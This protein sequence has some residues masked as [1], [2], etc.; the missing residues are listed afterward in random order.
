[1]ERT[2]EIDGEL[3]AVAAYLASR[4]EMLMQAWTT[5][6]AADAELTTASALPRTQFHDHIPDMLDAFEGRLRAWPGPDSG[7]ARAARKEDAGAHGLQR[8][9]QGYRLREV[10]REWGL[11]HLCL[12]DELDRY[13]GEGQVKD[14]ATMAIARR[15][16][17]QLINE[18]VGE[19]TAQYFRLR[20]IEAAGYVRDVEQALEQL[21]ELERRRAELWRQAA[22]D[23]RGNLG[24]LVNATTGLTHEGMPVEMREQFLR[25]LQRSVSSLHSMLDDVISL[26]RLQAGHESRDVKP[27]DVA[28]MLT[29]LCDT[30]RPVAGERG[31]Y[32]EMEGP[33]A[34]T[35]EGDAVKTRRIAQN[36]LL[37]ALKYTE[38]GGVTVSWGDSRAGDTERWMLC[39]R[40]TGPGFHAGPGAPLAGALEAATEEARQV[41][42]RADSGPGMSA[43]SE[44]PLTADSRPVHQERGE[45]IGL[46][47]VK[48]LCELLDAGIELESSPGEGTTFRVAFPRR[49]RDGPAA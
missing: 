31:L 17:I 48:R 9:Q 20:Q 33:D 2:Q 37:N 18:G 34:L 16:L 28:A 29:E 22:H 41:E 7:P 45:G 15:S 49:Y 25:L 39:V 44:P 14:R 30:L 26:A 38:Q 12:A 32:V 21:R 47:I 4:R 5:A 3:N 46:S 8:W 23:L 1:M 24:V 19:S 36:L 40:D 10:T 42:E 35:V 13:E 43:G 11:L 6:V 27:F